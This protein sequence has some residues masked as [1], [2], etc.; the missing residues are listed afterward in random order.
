MANEEKLR[1]I[2]WLVKTSGVYE[3][4]E[5]LRIK[6]IKLIDEVLDGNTEE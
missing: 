2:Q 3:I 6:L 4:E 1:L 5:N